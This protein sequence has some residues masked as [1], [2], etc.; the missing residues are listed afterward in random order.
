[1]LK[2]GGKM[3][4]VKFYLSRN[5]LAWKEGN[6]T[7]DL[8]FRGTKEELLQKIKEEIEKELKNDA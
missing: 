7:L 2:G 1:M 3:K 5:W 6:Y 8:R 4:L